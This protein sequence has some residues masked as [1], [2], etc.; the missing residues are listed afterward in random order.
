MAQAGCVLFLLVVV[1]ALIAP[2]VGGF[3]P[4]FVIALVLIVAGVVAACF[5][6]KAESWREVKKV[7]A[8][9]D[10]HKPQWEFDGP[11]ESSCAS[12]VTFSWSASTLVATEDGSLSAKTDRERYND[13]EQR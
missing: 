5:H 2:M 1:A 13:L 7:L 8:R 4:G 11:Q 12:S 6:M 3:G 9:I 10:S